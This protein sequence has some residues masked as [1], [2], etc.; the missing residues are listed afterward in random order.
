MVEF[1]IVIELYR[2]QS[3]TPH[4]YVVFE[5]KN[6]QGKIPTLYV[7]EFSS[8]L[9]NVFSRATKGV[10]VVSLGL[11]TGAESLARSSGMGIVKFNKHAPEFLANRTGRPFANNN[12]I[13]T[14]IFDDQNTVK[15]M[16]FSAYADGKFFNSVD[17]L[18]DNLNSTSTKYEK[19]TSGEVTLPI[20]FITKEEIRQAAQSLLG[21]VPINFFICS[22][23]CDSID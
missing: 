12:S 7:N 16:K 13:K 3:S 21:S 22:M 2:K 4:L 11:Q 15:S 23:I 6:H 9:D 1:D 8:R 18:L 10:I 17:Q 14:Q 20:P 19:Q 5:C